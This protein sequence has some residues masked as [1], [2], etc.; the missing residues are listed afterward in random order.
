MEK[1]EFLATFVRPGG[2]DEELRLTLAV[3]ENEKHKALRVLMWGKKVLKVT[4]EPEAGVQV[5]GR[6]VAATPED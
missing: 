4:I 3:P 2:D 1:A 5:K 6:F